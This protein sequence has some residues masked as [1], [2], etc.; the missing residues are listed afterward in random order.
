MSV[1][2]ACVGSIA[3]QIVSLK[4]KNTNLKTPFAPDEA[5]V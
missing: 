5:F 3:T 2:I 4:D 1:F